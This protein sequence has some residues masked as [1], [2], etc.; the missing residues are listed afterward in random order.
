MLA[1]NKIEDPVNMDPGIG[2]VGLEICYDLRFPEMHGILV[3]RGAGTLVFPSAFTLKTGRDHWGEST[4][5][6]CCDKPCL[7]R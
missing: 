5:R 3:D 7:L 2:N 1:G 6:E 4:S